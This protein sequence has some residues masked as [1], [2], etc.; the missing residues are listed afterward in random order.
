[1]SERA[2]NSIILRHA[3]RFYHSCNHFYCLFCLRVLEGKRR[4][5][6]RRCFSLSSGCALQCLSVHSRYYC[7]RSKPYSSSFH[8]THYFCSFCAS[9]AILFSTPFLWRRFRLWLRQQPPPLNSYCFN[10]LHRTYRRPS[11]SSFW[12]SLASRLEHFY[13]YF[14]FF[15]YGLLHLACLANGCHSLRLN[16]TT[17]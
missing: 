2:K 6:C 17:Y 1:M 15:F 3:A 5:S 14:D 16:F 7:H 4:S 10:C 11:I 8:S 9:C 12:P 13:C